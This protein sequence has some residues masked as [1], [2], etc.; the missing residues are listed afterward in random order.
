MR[1]KHKV[2]KEVVDINLR[3]NY[4]F[5]MTA[6]LQNDWLHCILPSEGMNNSNERISLTFRKIII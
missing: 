1:F 6:N 5:H 3:S 4:F 2:S